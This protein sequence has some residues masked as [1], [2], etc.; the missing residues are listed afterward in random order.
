MPKRFLNLYLSSPDVQRASVDGEGGEKEAQ[1]L[2]DVPEP[3]MYMKAL[4]PNGKVKETQVFI[5]QLEKTVVEEDIVEVFARFG[6]IQSV[7]VIRHSLTQKSKGF[8]FLQFSTAEAVVKALSQF[9][10]GTEVRFLTKP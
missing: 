5:S 8:A 7:R 6:E 4:L 2:G 9:K 1:E 3:T 10:D